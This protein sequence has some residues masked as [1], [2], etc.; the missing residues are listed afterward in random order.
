MKKIIHVHQARIRKNSKSGTADP[1][2]IVRT[3]KGVEYGNHIVLKDRAGQLVAEI[4]YRPQEPLSC[5]ARCWIVVP[6]EVEVEIE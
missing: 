2:I 5:G 1:P 6:D 3:Y 4:I